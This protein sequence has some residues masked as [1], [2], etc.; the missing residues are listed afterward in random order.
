ML[1]GRFVLRPRTTLV[2]Q[3]VDG[4]VAALVAEQRR[5][6]AVPELQ[7]AVWNLNRASVTRLS[8]SHCSSSNASTITTAARIATIPSALMLAPPKLIMSLSDMRGSPLK[9]QESLR[10]T[11]H[12]SCSFEM[13]S[14][15][16]EFALMRGKVELIEQA[17]TDNIPF[18][19]ML[20]RN[21][22]IFSLRYPQ[23]QSRPTRVSHRGGYMRDATSKAITIR[24]AATMAAIPS[25]LRCS[26]QNLT[27]SRLRMSRLSIENESQSVVGMG[28]IDLRADL[29]ARQWDKNVETPLVGDCQVLKT[30]VYPGPC[31]RYV[32]KTIHR[33]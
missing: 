29:R 31:V 25:A 3:V 8:Q 10:G 15:W 19:K 21:R 5:D 4:V 33:C 32:S 30:K 7:D 9:E 1:G 11:I 14:R 28:I 17:R 16:P 13:P 12:L 20:C 23:C 24:S 27:S 22:E 2:R 26:P 6:L 18:R